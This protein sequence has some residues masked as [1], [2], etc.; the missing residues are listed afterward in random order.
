MTQSERIRDGKIRARTP[1]DPELK[2]CLEPS[3]RRIGN[4]RRRQHID[5]QKGFTLTELLVSSAVLLIVVLGAL[6]IFS[7]SNKMSSDHQSFSDIQNE[8]RSAMY[9]IS[10]DIRGSGVGV[11]LLMAGYFV[12]GV[13]GYSPGEAAA[14][15]VLFIGNYDSSMVLR[16]ESFGGGIAKLY[17][18]ELTN[19][20]YACPGY[21]ENRTYLLQSTSCPNCFIYLFAGPGSVSGCEGGQEKIDFKD[22]ESDLPPPGKKKDTGCDSACW[23]DSRLS[24][25]QI[26]RFWL[27]ST[28]N[29]SDFPEM[30]LIVGANGY[31]GIADT[32]YAT[33]IDDSE[34]TIHLPL[35]M[36]IENIQFEYNG[37]LDDDGSLDGFTAWD[38]T[39]WTIQSGDD[40]STRAAKAD[41]IGRIRQVRIWVC[42]KTPN[43]FRSMSGSPPIN[44]HL[45]RRPSISNSAGADADDF[46][47]RFLLESTVSVRNLSLNI[48]NNGTR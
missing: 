41:I 13:D 6:S 23:N 24:P 14:D 19:S 20:P 39:N 2:L 8:V 35:A 36:N 47:R 38:N 33:T 46:H 30:G 28:G 25:I 45:Y 22:K 40:D 11:S 34:G 7:R 1:S 26:K 3:H 18:G 9:Y 43:P 16:V 27:D 12:E 21:F 17:A 44:I 48:Y 4:P 10:R 31:L 15:Q 32:F 37:D 29:P 5:C 42:G